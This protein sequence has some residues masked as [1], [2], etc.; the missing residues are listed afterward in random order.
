MILVKSPREDIF[1][2]RPILAAREP[3]PEPT[4]KPTPKPT[5][6][7]T[8]MDLAMEEIRAA[9]K[10]REEQAAL[11]EQ[12]MGGAFRDATGRMVTGISQEARDMIAMLMAQGIPADQAEDIARQQLGE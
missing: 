1:R 3:T 11:F 2:R 12:M 10:Q 5:P 6:E 7:P 8:P 4:P 9:Q